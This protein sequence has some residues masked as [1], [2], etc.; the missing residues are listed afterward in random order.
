MTGYIGCQESSY[1]VAGGDSEDRV[2]VVERDG[3]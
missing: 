3:K 1:I 2:V